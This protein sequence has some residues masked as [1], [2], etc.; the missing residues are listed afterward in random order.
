MSWRCW[1]SSHDPDHRRRRRRFVR[2]GPALRRSRT[3]IIARA[4]TGKT[5]TAAPRLPA[6]PG[7]SRPRRQRRP[8]GPIRSATTMSP[9]PP[10]RSPI[11]SRS[12]RRR[13]VRR[14]IHCSRSANA[15]R[16]QSI[17]AAGQ[18]PGPAPVATLPASS[19]SSAEAWPSSASY[20]KVLTVDDRPTVYAQF[21]P[22][23]AYPR[24]LR[25]RELYP[26]LPDAPLPAVITCIATTAAGRGAGHAQRLVAAVCDDLA[27]RGFAAVEAYPQEGAPPDSTSAATPAFWLAC[28]FE[29]AVADERFPVVRPG[30]RLR[31]GQRLGQRPGRKPWPA[32]VG[33]SLVAGRMRRELRR[34]PGPRSTR[35][36]ASP[37][38]SAVAAMPSRPS[39]ASRLLGSFGK[40]GWS[41]RSRSI[42][43]CWPSCLRRWAGSRSARSPRS[44]PNLVTDPTSS[45]TRPQPGRRARD[46][47]RRPA[48]SPTSR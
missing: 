37:P 31:L 26:Q 12:P 5:P 9:K 3:S 45:P 34:R 44:R 19:A 27:E 23:S 25:L 13:R 46:Q 28:G 18:R 42:R 48:T 2:P 4:T 41:R 21:G 14:S 8:G 47:H 38:S 35:T 6:W 40:S 15:D 32:L 30:A 43:A 29:L 11:R 10:G 39:I 16:R 22:L 17:C 33:L 24:A 20:A 7:S 1:S 36:P